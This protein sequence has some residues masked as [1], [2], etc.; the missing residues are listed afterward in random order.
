MIKVLFGKFGLFGFLLMSCTTLL[1]GP[2]DG[3]PS[4]ASV[5][6]GMAS[7]QVK[8]QISLVSGGLARLQVSRGSLDRY[9]GDLLDPNVLPKPQ[10]ARA[11]QARR[12]VWDLLLDHMV[13]GRP[14]ILLGISRLYLD[15]GLIGGSED[16]VSQLFAVNRKGNSKS[17]K[18][19][20]R[21]LAESTGDG[22]LKVNRRRLAE[23]VDQL[24]LDL[25][26]ET[27]SLY[28]PDQVDEQGIT[29]LELGLARGRVET[30]RGRLETHGNE[31]RDQLRSV[32]AF[33]IPRIYPHLSLLNKG[34]DGVSKV[35]LRKYAAD[36]ECANVH[37]CSRL[38]PFAGALMGP[39]LGYQSDV[40][41][42]NIVGNSM[43]DVLDSV[44]FASAFSI[45][46]I[47]SSG[48]GSKPFR[49]A[50]KILKQLRRQAVTRG[51][52]VITAVD[53]SRLQSN[54]DKLVAL[55]EGLAEI[56][57]APNGPSYDLDGFRWAARTMGQ[58]SVHIADGLKT[59]ENYLNAI[60]HE[61]L[62][63]GPSLNLLFSDLDAISDTLSGMAPR[64]LLV[65]HVTEDYLNHASVGLEG[66]MANGFHVPIQSLKLAQEDLHIYIDK[67]ERLNQLVDQRYYQLQQIELKP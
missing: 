53:T 15:S 51:A 8:Q 62:T 14:E 16:V 9:N 20:E 32:L 56:Y 38:L 19:L 5:F 1:A 31:I 34:Y 47:L 64:L 58:P 49:Q 41:M 11:R 55:T 13:L 23:Y 63:P 24:A 27:G 21:I 43:A 30:Y 2:S 61:A 60:G 35:G 67:V 57:Q 7:F 65:H 44:V 59:L 52:D 17:L 29:G 18:E 66:P 22:I 25:T 37:T 42:F 6:T 54:L 26:D 45:P 3:F 10:G 36:S 28:I 50:R 12:Y 33:L 4:C 40:D 46:A 39:I 48:L